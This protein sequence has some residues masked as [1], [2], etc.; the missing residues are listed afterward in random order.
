MTKM[1]LTRKPERPCLS[2]SRKMKKMKKYSIALIATYV[3]LI[4][5]SCA[6]DLGNYDYHD[7]EGLE[8]SG[9]KD[10]YGVLVKDRL[11]I[12]PS[13]GANASAE[14]D[15]NYEWKVISSTTNEETV[16]GEGKNLDY[17]M[18]LVPDIYTL[19]YKVTEKESGL[20]WRS[21]CELIVSDIYTEGWMVLCSDQGSARLDMISDVTSKTY[22][23]VLKGKGAPQYKGPRKIQWLKDKTSPD[24]PFYL[25][26]DE[27]ATRLG[28]NSFIWKP[29]YDFKYEVAI[30]KKLIPH[31]IVSAGFGKM[32]V[33]EG[34]AYYAEVM[35]I[36]GLYGNPVNKEFEVSPYIGANSGGEPYAALYLLY[37]TDAKRF[38]A[39]CPLMESPD[40]GSY[41]P[42]VTMPEM[43]EI[44][45]SLNKNG[46]SA[47]V[48][49]GF[50]EYPNG[51]DLLYMEN[52]QY[53]P[54]NGKMGRTCA[55]LKDESGNIWLYGIQMGDLLTFQDCPYV[56]GRSIKAD[57]SS[58]EEIKSP[59]AIFAFSS[60]KNYMYYAVRDKVYRVD[61]SAEHPVSELQIS[62]SGEEITCMK[63]N[64]YQTPAYQ[65][66]KKQYDL[67]VA[68]QDTKGEGKL[69]IYEGYNSDG[70]FK[71]VTPEVYDGFAKIV[72][73]SYRERN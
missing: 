51:M 25:L 24:S 5:S 38:M 11:L 14:G 43:E 15:Y 48:K 22:H 31:S 28:K 34:K 16:I 65:T 41:D 32:V 9:V 44:A 35:G 23:D 69:R 42:L 2:Q 12:T 55:I 56:I 6:R 40:L 29:E 54:G 59:E 33:S 27:G 8:I 57:L 17:E 19:F 26:T 68:S 47:V 60:L 53:D 39:Y 37:D 72:D 67:I 20:F 21:Q 64:L 36:D 49:T 66:K 4:M 73:V 18:L 7:I 30:S 62:L 52:T 1:H 63:F 46:A 71:N 61:L 45:I 13:L 50:D 10:S 3:V 58:C 70:D